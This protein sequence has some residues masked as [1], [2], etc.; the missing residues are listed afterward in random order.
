MCLWTSPHHCREGATRG[1]DLSL[2]FLSETHGKCV[3]VGAVFSD[4]ARVSIT[5]TT[6]V[7]NGLEIDGV[8]RA[9]GADVSYHCCPTC[10]S[11]T[12]WTLEGRNHGDRSRELGGSGLSSTNGGATY[13]FSSSLDAAC[14]GGRPVRRLP[15]TLNTII[16]TPRNSGAILEGFRAPTRRTARGQQPVERPPERPQL[17]LV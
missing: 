15:A 16:A 2:R 9:N 3:S 5:G 10:G 14:R 4:D 12:F 17:A 8:G 11:T 7:Y 1:P 13:A 6:Q